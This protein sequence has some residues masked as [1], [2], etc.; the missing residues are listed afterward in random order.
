MRFSYIDS[1]GK[2]IDVDSVESLALRIELGAIEDDTRLYDAVAD[3]WAPARDHP[4]YRSLSRGEEIVDD[5]IPLAPPP[6]PDEVAEEDDPPEDAPIDADVEDEEGLGEEEDEKEEEDEA[7]EDE[8]ESVD[9]AD[10][11]PEEKDRA[12]AGEGVADPQ[13][14]LA[15]DFDVDLR[16][17]ALTSE[18]HR[19][20]EGPAEDAEPATDEEF[21]TDE[22]PP[23]DEQPRADEQPAADSELLAD[24]QPSPEEAHAGEA[25]AEEAAAEE[26]AA[27]ESA[28]DDAAPD[29]DAIEDDALPLID[30]GSTTAGKGT[31]EGDR[32]FVQDD[33]PPPSDP[34]E[35]MPDWA[36]T[37]E[38][39]ADGDEYPDG[40]KLH[41]RGRPTA[42]DGPGGF[43]SE[44]DAAGSEGLGA[45]PESEREGGRPEAPRPAH[46]ERRRR[47]R[48]RR[49]RLIR[50]ASAALVVLLVGGGVYLTVTGGSG[51]DREVAERQEPAEPVLSSELRDVMTTVAE[52]A[53]GDALDNLRRDAAASD[54][55]LRPPG[56]W[57]DGRYL[58]T[59]DEYPAVREYWEGI[60]DA[61]ADVQSREES[62][63]LQQLDAHLSA[64]AAVGRPTAERA[65]EALTAE[66][67]SR[68]REAA[69]DA[70]GSTEPHRD[71][72]YRAVV[73]VATASLALH[74]LLVQRQADIDYEPYSAPGVSR[75]P[76]LEA[77][78]AD[79]SLRTTMNRQ[80]DRVL[81]SVERSGIPRPIT[82]AGI[83]DHLVRELDEVGV[84]PAEPQSIA[85]SLPPDS[86]PNRR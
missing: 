6:A 50:F 8:K 17:E 58:S 86:A 62:E 32:S 48:K 65:G 45:G 16:N 10:L 44:R 64:P 46:W 57:L 51:S 68:V 79:S 9:R 52:G 19:I 26:V 39:D 83:L 55:P 73:E 20:D 11:E 3:R 43:P 54:L 27:E 1:Q 61:I 23:A 33:P 60:R 28:G 36:R 84:V 67:A 77:V 35:R 4:V 12:E 53:Y 31:V 75:D 15:L 29:A 80:L 78:P 21:P 34:L 25:A 69:E 37:V 66:E 59:A 14:P 70:F 18:P 81:T 71:S 42:A 82:T 24:E 22:Q 30:G 72:V 2:E 5:D 76:V 13:D 49:A 63:F 7:E 74:E 38:E 41:E 47:T 85:D 56:T 40:E